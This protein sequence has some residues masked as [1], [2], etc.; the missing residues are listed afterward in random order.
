MAT[1]DGINI[2]LEEL[3][4]AATNIHKRNAELNAILENIKNQMNNLRNSWESEAARNIQ[5]NFSSV[6][7]KFKQYFD[8]IESYSDFLVKTVQSYQSTESTNISNAAAF[9]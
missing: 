3:N 1:I 8:V 6:E 7:P 2:T 4:S 5:N 9:E